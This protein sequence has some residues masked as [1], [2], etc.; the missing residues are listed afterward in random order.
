MYFF[1]L[2]KTWSYFELTLLC[3]G[4]VSAQDKI[5]TRTDSLC[6]LLSSVSAGSLLTISTSHHGHSCNMHSGHLS[7]AICCCQQVVHKNMSCYIL[8]LQ[9]THLFGEHGEF[10]ED[11]FLWMKLGAKHL[12]SIPSENILCGQ[13]LPLCQ[14]YDCSPLSA[15]SCCCGA[16]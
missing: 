15:P 3:L 8:C 6:A 4:H 16:Y 11:T 7:R 13:T 5:L 10:N 14:L 1:Y 2:L 12:I 9:M